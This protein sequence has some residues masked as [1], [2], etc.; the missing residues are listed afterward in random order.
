MNNSTELVHSPL[1]KKKMMPKIQPEKDTMSIW[2]HVYMV[3]G[4]IST[5]YN[6]YIVPCLLD[7][8]PCRHRRIWRGGQGGTCPPWDFLRDPSGPGFEVASS[9][10]CQ[11]GGY[12]Y[13]YCVVEPFISLSLR[14]GQYIYRKGMPFQH[15]LKH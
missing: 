15:L 5:Q 2:Y 10:F 9:N 4:A 12:R 14:V 6:V 3:L 1:F 7:M 13:M 11:T 8:V